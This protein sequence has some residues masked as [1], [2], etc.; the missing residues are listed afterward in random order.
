M[1]RVWAKLFVGLALIVAPGFA[2]AAAPASGI[3][4]QWTAERTDPGSEAKR[5]TIT[6]LPIGN[7]ATGTF[8]VGDDD[9][10]IVDISDANGQI[11]FTLILPGRPLVNMRYSGRRTDTVMTLASEGSGSGIYRLTGERIG[12]PPRPRQAAA[13]QPTPPAPAPPPQSVAAA[14]PPPAPPPQRAAAAPPPAPPP[15]AQAAVGPGVPSYIARLLSQPA[16]GGAPAQAPQAASP[17]SPPP[18]PQTRTASLPAPAGQPPEAGLTVRTS[19]APR[20]A[21]QT[22]RLEGEWDGFLTAPGKAEPVEVRLSFAR[23]AGALSGTLRQGNASTLLFEV[24]QVGSSVSF[25]QVIPGTPYVT[26]SYEG[27]LSGNRLELVSKGEIADAYTITVLRPGA[28]EPP[29][30]VAAPAPTVRASQTAPAPRTVPTAFSLEGDWNGQLTAPDTSAPEAVRLSFASNAGVLS[31]T[32]HNGAES[33]PL[34]EIRQTGSTL[35]FML[36]IAGTPYVTLLYEGQL[37][38]GRMELSSTGENGKTYKIVAFKVTASRE[39]AP[40]EMPVVADAAEPAPSPLLRQVAAVARTPEAPVPTREPQPSAPSF[41]Q[42]DLIPALRD[43][44]SPEEMPMETEEAPKPPP[45]QRYV[46]PP[47]ST[48]PVAKLPLPSLSDIKP[49]ESLQTP[50]MGWA[51]R[52]RLGTM[53]DDEAIR[54]AADGLEETGLKASGFVFVEVGDGWQGERGATGVLASNPEFPNMKALGDYL[55]GKGVKFALQTAAAPQSCAGY[56]GSYGHEEQDAK[57]FAA[58]GVDLLVYDWCGAEKIYPALTETRA[59][60]QRMAEALL[61]SGRDI[62]LEFASVEGLD[63][64]GFAAHAGVNIVRSGKDVED[65]FASAMATGF[66]GAAPAGGSWPDP[67]LL[68][69]GNGGMNANEYRAQINLWAVLGAPMMLGNDVRIMRKETVELLTNKE[70]LAINQDGL[71]RP[72]VKVGQQGNVGVFAKTLSGGATAL[73]F[74]NR[75]E[76]SAPASVSWEQLGITGQRQVRDVWWHENLGAA[77]NRY[78]SFLTAHTS[79]LLVLTP[80]RR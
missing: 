30:T 15:Q 20:P 76:T 63:A 32:L 8:R 12:P 78:A 50:P 3:E 27:L 51:S 75:G 26:V 1:V 14:S 23:N 79:L 36:V 55:H 24:K 4:G 72:G 10:P 70:A 33:F 44:P 52:Q 54:Q 17:P 73:L 25:Q 37:T 19:Q 6:F 48:A 68:Q 74:V 38:A 40:E 53:I 41:T 42:E 29:P 9:L 7:S 28:P 69:A 35:S 65:D 11:S 64:S 80:E 18:Q 13:P 43:A 2:L 49:S 39:G 67:G 5:G 47:L 60:V 56:T 46:P 77:N 34:F 45:H 31:G 62:A 58:W 71:A 59:A 21:P 57:T 22:P 66:S 61:A 16:V